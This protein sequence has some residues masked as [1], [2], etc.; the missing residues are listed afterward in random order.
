MTITPGNVARLH[1]LTPAVIGDAEL[2]TIDRVLEAGAPLLQVRLEDVTDREHLRVC[3]RL[4]ARCRTAGATCIVNDRVDL[5]LA[6]AADGV[7]LGADDLPVEVA[8]GILGPAALVGGTCRNPDDARRAELAGASY[9]GAGPVSVSTTKD[10]LPDPIGAA[11]IE[12]IA[13]AVSIPVIAIG[14]VTAPMVPELL[15]AGAHGVAVIAA[16]F[17]APDPAAAT[18]DLLDEIDAAARV[19]S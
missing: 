2:S 12:K 16:V 18:A 4:R 8:R 15:G 19:T 3:R 13:A 10:G 14:G 17:A 6:V 11:T 1:V 9:V 7:H 5:A